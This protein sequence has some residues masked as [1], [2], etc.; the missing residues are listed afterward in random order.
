MNGCLHV[1]RICRSNGTSRLVNGTLCYNQR[2]R[3]INLGN[4]SRFPHIFKFPRNHFP[5]PKGYEYVSEKLNRN[6][7]LTRQEANVMQVHWGL[8]NM[9]LIAFCSA[10]IIGS[11]FFAL[12]PQRLRQER[13]DKQV[14]ENWVN[15]NAQ[16]LEGTYIE[17]LV[18]KYASE[19]AKA[20]E[21]VKHKPIIDK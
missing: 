13:I 15:E 18:G 6:E 5:M 3:H 9:G 21:A 19:E 1:T 7:P 17:G 11:A 20:G 12:Y 8:D 14:V 10:I 4:E 16:F 2:I